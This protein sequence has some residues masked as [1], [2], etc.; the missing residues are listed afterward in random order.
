MFINNFPARLVDS[1]AETVRF[2]GGTQI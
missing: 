2:E 1:I